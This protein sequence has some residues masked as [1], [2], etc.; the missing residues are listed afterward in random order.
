MAGKKRSVA[1]EEQ[2]MAAPVVANEPVGTASIERLRMIEAELRATTY[3][4]KGMASALGLSEMYAR[5]RAHNGKVQG[6]IVAGAWRFPV[7]VVMA[8]A[9]EGGLK[10]AP[11]SG[12]LAEPVD[13]TEED[14]SDLA[15]ETSNEPLEEVFGD[16]LVGEDEPEDTSDPLEVS[17]MERDAE[18][19]D[20]LEPEPVA[21]K[22]K[23]SLK[24]PSATSLID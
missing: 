7:D 11:R 15:G 20:E 9:A 19:Q 12:G 23:K 13:S 8:I 1:P 10:R 17:T 2:A 24:R 14:I 18:L 5:N 16:A 6:V 21:P 22:A 4:I 3:D